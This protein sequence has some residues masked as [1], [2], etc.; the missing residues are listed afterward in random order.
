MVKRAA[1]GGWLEAVG[2]CP[3]NAS[4]NE[5]PAGAVALLEI[6][7]RRRLQKGWYLNKKE[8]SPPVFSF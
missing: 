4:V 5:F 7:N 8:Q 1:G 3:K 2:L 6:R